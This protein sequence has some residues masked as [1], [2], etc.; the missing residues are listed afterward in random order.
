M[1]TFDTVSTIVLVLGLSLIVILN[2]K[3]LTFQRGL[4]IFYVALYRTKAGIKSIDRIAKKHTKL[5]QKMSWTVIIV[6]FV[7]MIIVVFDLSRS[8]LKLVLGKSTPTVGVVLPIQ[9]KGVFYVPFIYWI[10]CI[11][12]ILVIH[13]GSHGVMAKAL[14][15]PVKNSGLLVMGAIIPLIPGAFVEPDEKKLVK[16]STKKQLAVYG[17]GP[18]AN[19]VAGFLFLALL[20]ALFNPIADGLYSKD[21]VVVTSLMDGDNPAKHAGL[22]AGEKIVGI[23]G[24]PINDVEEF[25]TAIRSKSPGDKI[26]MVTSNAV[27]DIT[28]SEN[29]ANQRP[30][31]GVYVEQPLANPN[32][33]SKGWLWVKDFVF[34]LFVLNLGVGL[35]N[36]VP[37]GPIDG[38]RMLL[39]VLQKYTK[40]TKAH[41]IW[42]SVSFC[43]LGILLI[44]VL[45]AF[46]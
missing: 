31:L 10:L 23:N 38:G 14:G 20:M 29:P 2:R 46:F 11:F 3:K 28:L 41:R 5:I 22:I 36:L 7:G 4:G 35:F 44:N 42:K 8:I 24:K 37:L 12:I 39:C 16:A 25:S 33:F 40:E 15:L 34:W 19:I 17:A 6:G 45:A 13:E 43:V 26:N 32:L 30:W 27:Y 9:A 21:G 18:F 1:V